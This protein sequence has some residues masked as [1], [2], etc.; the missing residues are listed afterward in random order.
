VLDVA[1]E[2]GAGPREKRSSRVRLT[3]VVAGLTAAN[4]VNAA[5]GFITAPLL[6]RAL[7]ASGRGDLAA[8]A[9]PLSL[10]PIVLSLGIPRF[11]NRMVP[12]G[13]PVNGVIGSL[14]VPL[15]IVGALAAAAAVPAANALSGGRATVRLYL[16]ITFLA[17]PILLVEA[18]L[19]E[20]L[21]GLERW[22]RLI[23]AQFIPFAVPF[24]GIVVL[25]P[26]H[27]L[28]VSTAAAL[29]ITGALLAMVPALPLLTAGGRPA[30]SLR[31]ATE[32]VRFGLKSWLGGLAQLANLR[33]DQFLMIAVVTPRELGWY[34]VASSFS[35]AS[36]A[37]SGAL[38]PPLMTRVAAGETELLPRAVRIILVGTAAFNI[39]LGLATP[40][41]FGDLLG[42]QFRGAILMAIVLL[43]ATVPLIGGSVL[44][45]GLQADGAPMI[46]SIAEAAALVIT[47]VG[48]AILLPPLGGLGAAVVS[49]AAYSTSFLLQL[50]MARRRSGVPLRAYL[51]PTRE[52]VRWGVD[53]A[54]GIIGRL[55]MA[56]R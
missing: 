10:I 3:G 17:M 37:V 31:L 28:T 21:V 52:D 55:T 24:V 38:A 27:R 41:L 18:L 45:S 30:F 16:I 23:V 5:L 12:R 51:I 26:L 36:T 44:S 56:A 34:A 20:C 46:P 47:V 7:G 14:G 29:I 8:I 15:L 43:I 9:V 6:A 49:L 42:P 25:Y 19:L 22:R 54:T 48:L 2:S 39:L 13:T 11:A 53:L 35:G 4:A 33:L 50:V 40:I 1:V 32:G